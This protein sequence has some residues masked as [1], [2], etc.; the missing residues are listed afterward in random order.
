[1]GANRTWRAAARALFM[2][3]ALGLL[4]SC[5][6][7]GGGDDSAPLELAGNWRVILVENGTTYN[8][9]TVPASSVPTQEEVASLSTASFA[10]VFAATAYEAYTVTLNGATLTITGPGTN[11][12]IVINSVAGSNYQG[13]GT[14]CGIGAVISYEVNIGFT[15]NGTADNDP[16]AATTSESGV[17]G[18]Y[19]RV[20]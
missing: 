5:G 15:A 1:M 10:Q 16:V 3:L 18:R 20:D 13:C 2:A 17:V 12:T 14:P 6:G 4:V 8:G 9:G 11:L 7:G 19:V